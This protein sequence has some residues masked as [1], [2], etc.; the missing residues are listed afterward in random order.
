MD[1]IGAYPYAFKHLGLNCSAYATTP[2]HDLGQACLYDLIESKKA[3]EPF[4]L[5]Q[6]EDVHK[7]F[8]KV[9]MLRYSQ[10]HL[11][12]GKCDGITITAFNSGHSVGGAIWKIKKDTEE[13]VYAVDYN[14]RKERLILTYMTIL[15]ILM[16]QYYL[17]RNPYKSHH[18]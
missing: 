2:V 8:K 9:Q 16:A 3:Q 7:A 13:I 18:Y 17:V 5:F 10:P 6:F 1:H 11:L 14:H 12:S 15:D 4:D